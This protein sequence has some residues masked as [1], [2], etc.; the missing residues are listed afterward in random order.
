MARTIA[1]TDA[2]IDRAFEAC[3]IGALHGTV[4]GLD[5]RSADGLPH[6]VIPYAGVDQH[7]PDVGS[8]M[9]RSPGQDAS[10]D[11]GSEG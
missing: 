4:I 7:E 5:R 6:R 10:G 8:G 2:G 9:A 3:V 1:Q 11:G